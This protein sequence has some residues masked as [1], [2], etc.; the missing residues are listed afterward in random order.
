MKKQNGQAALLIVLVL[1]VILAGLIFFGWSKEA[2]MSRALSRV[3][4]AQ[5][6]NEALTAAAKK[7]QQIYVNDGGCDPD[8]LETALKNMAALPSSYG[9]SVVYAIASP[10]ASSTADRENRCTGGTGCR[11]L[12]V[13]QN[14][15]AYIVNVGRVAADAAVGSGDCPRDATVRLRTTI[16]QSIF[17]RRVTLINLCS[18]TSCAGPS[19]SDA[20][21]NISANST[22]STACNFV[23]SRQY[24]DI[25]GTTSVINEDDLRWARRYLDSGGA[26][27]GYT[28]Y[29]EVSSTIT[30]G[31]GSCTAAAS[32][33]QCIQKN[34]IPAFDLDLSRGNNE[35]D[36]AI[37]EYYLR[38]YLT[39]LPVR[40]F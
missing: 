22:T 31:N 3:D 24:G 32:S 19:F 5:I 38:G 34:C 27:V 36:L 37:M 10:D 40:N 39:S 30:S 16:R 6:A 12:A 15:R 29:M 25:V 33:S 20:S 23:P 9:G 28:N 1:G 7:V 2:E 4:A 21:S 14:G 26:D 13:E 18:Y 11:Q 8:R 17:S 35:A